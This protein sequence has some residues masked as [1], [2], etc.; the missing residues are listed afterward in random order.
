[1]HLENRTGTNLKVTV[2][3]LK[4]TYDITLK[5]GESAYYGDLKKKD[6]LKITSQQG[7]ATILMSEDELFFEGTDVDF[8]ESNVQS[9]GLL[10]FEEMFVGSSR[11]FSRHLNGIS[12]RITVKD[13]K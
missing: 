2:I 13:Y 9:E 6:V 4:D 10:Q 5:K 3:E 7:K 11:T 8:V 1:M 12:I